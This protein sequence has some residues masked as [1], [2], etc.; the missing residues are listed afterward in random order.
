M[1]TQR[2]F[3]VGVALSVAPSVRIDG[4]SAPAE[5]HIISKSYALGFAA[6]LLAGCTGSSSTPITTGTNAGGGAPG[7]SV[8]AQTTA[9]GGNSQLLTTIAIPGAT[10]AS[11]FH[12]DAASVDPINNRYYLS[13]RTNKSVDVISTTTNRVLR[14]ITGGFTGQTASNETSGPNAALVQTG[15]NLVYVSDINSV[16]IVDGST[17]VLIKNI[18]VLANGKPT[19]NRVDGG[20]YD[21]VDQV[22][23]V[24]S[25]A[26][27][28]STFINAKTQT[29]IAQYLFNS[30]SGEVAQGLETCVYD[31]SA[32]NFYINNDGYPSTTPNGE[33]DVLPAANV[34]AG[35]PIV[36]QSLDYTTANVTTGTKVT[37][38]ANA[39][40]CAPAGLALGPASQIVTACDPPAGTPL[41]T[42]VVNDKT[43]AITRVINQV[44]GSDA[45]AY[46]PTTNVFYVAA[47]HYTANGVA[48]GGSAPSTLYTPVLGVLPVIGGTVTF[49]T[50]LSTGN[51]A[52]SVA[53]DPVTGH[54][55]VPV[56]P[57]ATFGGG[58]NVYANPSGT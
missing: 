2:S 57:T 6:L 11:G 24:N 54:T 30:P 39:Y 21:P 43:L 49:F 13:D 37:P 9:S 12:F 18:P 29:V 48:A 31:P 38:G 14:Q 42:L 3:T 35:A 55:F 51:N 17:G 45:V 53:T 5:E 15:T 34:V 23:M 8:P 56:P 32:A 26:D 19:G 4:R 46:N 47:R 33:L 44:G 20:C 52:N 58:I 36:T 27:S 41:A 7:G 50:N 28:I 40:P 1:I 25:P 10:F 16:K 22:F